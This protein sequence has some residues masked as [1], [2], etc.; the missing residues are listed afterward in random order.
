MQL[1]KL[2]AL[3]LVLYQNTNGIKLEVLLTSAEEFTVSRINFRYLSF[4]INVIRKNVIIS[5]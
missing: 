5:H 3:N 4:L 1:V 2:V